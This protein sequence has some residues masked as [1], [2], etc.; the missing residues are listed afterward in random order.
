MPDKCGGFYTR[1]AVSV[2]KGRATD[3]IHLDLCKAFDTVQ[4]DILVS[5]LER[6][7]FGRRTSQWTRNRLDGHTQ[8]LEVNDLTAKWRPTPT[9]IPRRQYWDQCCLTPF[10]DSVRLRLGFVFKL[11]S[12][13]LAVT[14]SEKQVQKGI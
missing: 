13:A 9:G 11:H 14:D 5:E 8:R 7:A 2:G 4:H 10:Y 6:H 3:I 12:K 1:V